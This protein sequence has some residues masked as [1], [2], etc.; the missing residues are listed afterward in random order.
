MP[1]LVAATSALARTMCIRT[2]YDRT[3]IQNLRKTP[4]GRKVSGRKESKTNNAKFSG[5]YACQ[6][7]H[8]VQTKIPSL[9]L[10]SKMSPLSQAQ[11]PPHLKCVL[12]IHQ[13]MDRAW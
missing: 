10:N 1:S 7:M 8:N 6:R 11:P 4:S 12:N 2:H 9:F 13:L 5:T 3:K